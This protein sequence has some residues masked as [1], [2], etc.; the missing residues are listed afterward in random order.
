VKGTFTG[1]SPFKGALQTVVIG[2]LAAAVAFL[3][4]KLIS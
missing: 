1:I 4:A 3:I 2:G